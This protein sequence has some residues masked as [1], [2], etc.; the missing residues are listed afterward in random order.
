[1][2]EKEKKKRSPQGR[3]K[4]QKVKHGAYSLISGSWSR[5]PYY[6]R[7]RLQ[8]YLSGVREG[9]IEDQGGE[10]NL[11]TARKVLIDRVIGKIG[12]V[13]LIEEHAREEGVFQDGKL[14]DVL[15][16]N[17]LAYTNSIRHD[18][19]ALGLDPEKAEG[20]GVLEYIEMKEKGKG[21]G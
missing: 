12:I 7:K 6:K 11:S 3:R 20:I 1:M 2:S 16:A 4:G 14:A 18:L 9:L 5:I 10:A 21:E 17:Y 19:T 13:R 8:G 15:G